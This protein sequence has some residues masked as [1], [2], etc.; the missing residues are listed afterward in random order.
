MK[1]N[2]GFFFIAAVLAL[3]PLLFF[4]SCQS[5]SN[6]VIDNSGTG[7]STGTTN[8]TVTGII[9]ESATKT[10]L[11][12]AFVTIYYGSGIASGYTGTDGKYSIQFYID[13]SKTVL[14]IATKTGYKPDTLTG[15]VAKNA[16]NNFGNRILSLVGTASTKSGPPAAIYLY[17]QSATS[18][19]IQGPGSPV[20]GSLVFQVVDSLGH[21]IDASHST[22]VKFSF[23]GHPNGGEFLSPQP[24]LVYTDSTGRATVVLTSGTKAGPVQVIAQV[25]LTDHSI[26]SLPVSYTIFGGLPQQSHFGIAAQY[27]NFAGYD[28]FGQ[29]DKLTAYL[30]DRYGNPVKPNTSVYFTTTGGIIEGMAQTSSIGAGTVSLISSEPRPIHPTRGA[31]F[32]TVTAS[33]ADENSQTISTSMDILFSGIPVLTISPSSFDIPNAGSQD[34]TFEVKDENGNPLAPG[35]NISVT[36]EGDNVKTAG[37]TSFEMPDTQSKYY[38]KFK[39]QVY[40]SVDTIN[41]AKPISIKLKSSG[42][43]GNSLLSI[44][45][46]SR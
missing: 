46:V 39:F 13:T 42:P 4:M 25:D 32:A 9:L 40:D 21:A 17:S 22:L 1:Q 2:P 31:G 14:I 7:G 43:N 41:I 30:G 18:L 11:D 33:T 12:S 29:Q 44:S 3:I 26:Y 28:I 45:G 6:P 5:T 8:V 35:T 16:V 36:V 15:Y 20:T 19:G 38:T 24:S 27:L 37:E 34:F 10:V 23:G